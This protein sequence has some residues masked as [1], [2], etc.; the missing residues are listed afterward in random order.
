[1]ATRV[2]DGIKFCVQFLKRTPPKEHSCRVWSRFVKRFGRC[3]KKLLTTDD[4]HWTTLKAP[5]S[6]LCSGELKTQ[7]N[8]LF[9]T[10]SIQYTS[11]KP[12]ERIQT[13][14]HGFKEHSKSP[15]NPDL[16]AIGRNRFDW[17]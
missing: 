12:T 16:M 5:L 14:S 10:H 11:V 13:S 2:F 3:L 17:S 7:S 1:M 9:F 8:L 15:K 4:R 6:M